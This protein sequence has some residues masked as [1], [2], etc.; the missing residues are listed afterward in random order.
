M[1]LTVVVPAF[2]EERGI[3]ETVHS[4][5]AY[6]SRAWTGQWEVVV[7]DDAS[8]DGTAAAVQQVADP[9]VRLLS[10]QVNQGKGG[11]IKTGAVA[12][13][14]D[15][16]LLMDADSSTE[17]TELP[18]LLNALEGAD[19]AFGSRGIAGHRITV[20]QPWYRVA[21]GKLGNLVIQ[22]LVLP[23]VRDSQCG[24]KL[25]GPA[26]VPLLAQL[27][28]RGWGVD[29]ELLGLA[30]RRGLTLREV[31]VEWRHDDSSS[32]TLVGYLRTLAEVVR[33]ALRLRQ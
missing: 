17:I 24:F 32:V 15:H 8:T 31:P 18:K 26:A 12:A 19:V 5:T 1:D 10:H 13:T 25:L 30:K 22:L 14:Y 9:R 33:I 29:V 23:G 2:N 7:V 28:C 11:A 3:G 16:V 20:S 4:I 21:L 6:L 27:R